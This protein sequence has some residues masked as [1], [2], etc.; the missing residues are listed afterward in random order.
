M[1]TIIRQ[2]NAKYLFKLVSR[3]PRRRAILK[4]LGLKFQLLNN[5][6]KPPELIRDFFYRWDIVP[7]TFKKFHGINLQEGEALIACDTIVVYNFRVFGKPRNRAQAVSFLQKLSGKKHYVLSCIAIKARSKDQIRSYYAVEKTAVSFKKLS[8]AEIA[9]YVATR[10]PFDK[11]GGYGIQ[12]RA[13]KFVNKVAG[14]Y[15]NVVGLPVEK[16]LQLL[17]KL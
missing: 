12:G 15:D 11:A 13:K 16:F 2:A 5:P 1:R 7:E 17:T 9:A 8:P 3:S 6:Y 4:A 10:E 14:S